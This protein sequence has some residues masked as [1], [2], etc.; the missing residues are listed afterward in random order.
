[1]KATDCPHTDRPNRAR[2]LC[3]SCYNRQRFKEDPARYE[4][5]KKSSGA[6]AKRRAPEQ[7]RA[8]VL[9]HR[10]GIDNEDYARMLAAQRGCCAICGREST[11]RLHVDHDHSTGAVRA[12]LCAGCNLLVGAMENPLR[13]AAQAYLSKYKEQS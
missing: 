13:A 2:G 11:R 5:A 10:Y 4:R 1:M 9:R 12:L 3:G 8:R 6:A 7:Q